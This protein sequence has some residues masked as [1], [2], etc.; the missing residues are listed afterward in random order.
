LLVQLTFLFVHGELDLSFI[1]SEKTE[2]AI[3]VD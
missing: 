1:S 2:S 3:F